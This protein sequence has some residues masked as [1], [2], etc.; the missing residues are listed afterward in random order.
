MVLVALS[1]YGKGKGKGKCK[2]KV[3]CGHALKAYEG[4]EVQLHLFVSTR[5]TWVVSFMPLPLYSQRKSLR[6]LLNRRLHG[7][8]IQSSTVKK[9]CISF[10]C[11]QSNCHSWG[12]QSVV[13]SLYWLAYPMSCFSPFISWFQRSKENKEHKWLSDYLTA[14]N[15]WLILIIARK[16]YD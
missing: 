16:V 12:V 7:S 11:W 8:Q 10:P 3:A 15:H 5:G 4:M 2:D 6:Y 13:Q 9:N 14:T 1:L